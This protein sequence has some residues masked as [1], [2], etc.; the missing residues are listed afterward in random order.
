M[1]AMDKTKI[2]YISLL[3]GV[4]LLVIGNGLQQTLIGLRAGIEEYADETVGVMMSAYFV[5]FILASIHAPGVIQRVGHIRAFAAFASAGSIF[6][7]CF[8]IFL[9]PPAWVA[10]RVMQGAC[11]AGLVIVV[12]SWLNASADAN[13]RGRVLAIYS[14]VMYAAWAISQPMVGLAPP[15]GFVLFA[16][17]SICLSLAL[18][19]ITLSRA[20]GP[21]VVL[22]TRVG[23]RRLL[24][25]SP[26][27]LAGTFT[28]GAV[29]GAYFSM[30]PSVNH[31]LGSSAAATGWTLSATLIGALVFQWPLGWLSDRLDRRLVI[32]AGSLTGVAVGVLFIGMLEGRHGLPASVLAFILGGTLMPL[33]SVCLAEVNDRIDGSEMIAAASGFVLVY[34]V[35]SAAGPFVAGLVIGQTGPSGLFIFMTGMLSLFAVF[36]AL[37]IWFRTKTATGDKQ[38]YV[39]TPCTSHAALPLHVNCPDRAEGEAAPG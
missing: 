14:I 32:L 31:E 33:Y 23:L 16:V 8:A 39:P 22:A 4:A 10:L 15:S 3:L 17:V 18:V 37:H 5:G 11:Y 21:G 34:G 7:L 19:P 36:D 6:A 26:V 12:E 27:A 29:V 20:G 38:G 1:M 9:S 2:R 28:M 35:G 25:I 30:W 13:W 24:A